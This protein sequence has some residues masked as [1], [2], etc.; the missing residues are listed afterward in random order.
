MTVGRQRQWEKFTNELITITSIDQLC[1]DYSRFVTALE[2]RIGEIFRGAEPDI[3]TLCPNFSP[4]LTPGLAEELE[5]ANAR[6]QL[7]VLTE[8]RATEEKANASL[9]DIAGQLAR[10]TAEAAIILKG[11]E[12]AQ[13]KV[14]GV[15]KSGADLLDGTELKGIAKSVKGNSQSIS[16]VDSHVD[17][18][19]SKV[20]ELINIVSALQSTMGKDMDSLKEEIESVHVDVKTPIIV[21]RLF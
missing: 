5:L 19:K 9:Q 4:P 11:L 20:T 10:F 3:D 16:V 15:L 17:A 13:S 1:A 2:H 18:L 8:L 12:D 6:E 21:K 14:A 7:R